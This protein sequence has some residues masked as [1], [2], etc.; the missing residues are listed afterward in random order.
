MVYGGHTYLG[1]PRP[2]REAAGIDAG[3]VVEIVLERDDLPRE[4]EVPPALAEALAGDPVARAAFEG[5]S[6]THR[7]EYATWIADAKRE[8]TRGRRVAKALEMLAGGVP[9]P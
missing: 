5:L 4:V 9:H 8:E 2:V 6:F 1:F 3:S 7:R